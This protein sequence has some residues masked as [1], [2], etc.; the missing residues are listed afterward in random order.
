MQN[1][2]LKDLP[3]NIIEFRTTMVFIDVEKMKGGGSSQN[4]NNEAP[5]WRLIYKQT[6]WLDFIMYAN[7][8]I[9]FALPIFDIYRIV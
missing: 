9:W 6:K 7:R 5:N 3:R 4:D 8:K 2:L 1:S